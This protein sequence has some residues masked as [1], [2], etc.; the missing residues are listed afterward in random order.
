MREKESHAVKWETIRKPKGLRGLGLR[1]LDIIKKACIL[2]HG[3]KIHNNVEDLWGKM[4]RNN[5]DCNS[6]EE[7]ATSNSSLWK[8]IM[9]LAPR[10]FSSD[11]WI[12]GG[13]R[14][15]DAWSDNWL[16]PGLHMIDDFD[17]SK[18]ILRANLSEI[19]DSNGD[20]IF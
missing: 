10:M 14:E 1:R 19:V 18:E 15:I 4:L 11:S 5:Y 8:A 17:I 13:G 6:F 16:D 9:K 2:K 12:V 3:W 7:S 20:W